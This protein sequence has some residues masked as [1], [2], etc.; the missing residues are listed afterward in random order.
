MYSL[1]RFLRCSPFDEYR[2]RNRFESANA[3]ADNHEFPLEQQVWKLWVD[4]KSPSGSTRLNTLVKCLLMRRT[5][6]QK[7]LVSGEEIVKL[8][9]KTVFEHVLQLSDKERE[10]IA[11]TVFN[12][13]HVLLQLLA[14]LQ[15]Y[16]EVFSF[17][18]QA[19]LQ[20]MQQQEEK[21]EDNAFMKHVEKTGSAAGFRFDEADARAKGNAHGH[22]HGGHGTL[23]FG[24]DKNV[25]THHLLVLLLRL[26]QVSRESFFSF[27]VV[28]LTAETLNYSLATKSRMTNDRICYLM[29]LLL[30]R[31]IV[32]FLL[33]FV[34]I[35][36]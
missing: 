7:C 31:T 33:R 9:K 35:R 18:Q 20:Y 15:V 2:V 6:D 27:S 24:E 14:S 29:V 32:L 3:R 26:R 16:Q 36:C 34:V 12:I 28:C 8:P 4:N 30:K 13:S 17:S 21:S 11:V 5:K 10:V 25:K 19:M 1:I 22:A 23:S